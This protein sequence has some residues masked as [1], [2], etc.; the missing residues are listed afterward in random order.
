MLEKSV[1]SVDEKVK[2]RFSNVLFSFT[3]YLRGEWS[4]NCKV[5]HSVRMLLDEKT[6][7]IKIA[8]INKKT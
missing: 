2:D 6:K 1:I 4:E 7:K 5:A 3:L 8:A